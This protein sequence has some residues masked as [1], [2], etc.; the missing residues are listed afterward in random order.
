MYADYYALLFTFRQLKVN[1]YK[2]ITGVHIS[3]FVQTLQKQYEAD[4]AFKND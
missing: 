4:I 1:L 3:V 2:T